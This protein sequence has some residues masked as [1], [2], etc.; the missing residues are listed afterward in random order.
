VSGKRYFSRYDSGELSRESRKLARR[1]TLFVL[2]VCALIDAGLGEGAISGMGNVA[3]RSN[4]LWVLP[5]PDPSLWLPIACFVL[6]Q[7]ILIFALIRLREPQ[8]LT[9]LTSR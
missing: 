4:G 3:Y 1:G 9:S 7:G 5:Q 8:A 6:F 2:F